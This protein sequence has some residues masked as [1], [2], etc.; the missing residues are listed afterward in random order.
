MFKEQQHG[1]R[2]Y[3]D[4]DLQTQ[5][6]KILPGEFYAT[7][8]PTTAIATLLGSCV[9]VC[10]FDPVCK[11]GGMNHFMLPEL[12][13]ETART[14]CERPSGSCSDQCSARYGSCAMRKLLKNMEQLGANLPRLE[15]KVFGAGRVLARV[16]DI[17]DKNASFALGY[18]EERGI[19][20]IAQ[21]LGAKCP[22]KIVF[23]PTTGRVLVKRLR[24]LPAGVP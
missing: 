6:V 9:S 2:G 15:A 1:S 18:L 22:R 7:C 17:G 3:F 12:W 24:D 10:L 21:D 23:F 20:V 5:V 16:T 4:P 19:R 8:E 14:R 11:V 13:N